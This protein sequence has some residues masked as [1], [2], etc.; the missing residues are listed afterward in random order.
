MAVLYSPWGNSQFF[1]ANG[2]PAN[3][4]KIYTYVAGSSTP[5][6]TY[7]DSTGTVAQSNPIVI[8]SLGFPTTGQIWLTS[9]LSY[10]LVLT[11]ASDVVK[12]TQDNL[13]G[14]LS[15]SSSTLSQWV[16]SGLTPTYVSAT[17]FTLAGDQTSAFHVGRRLQT[18]NTSGMIYSR[19]V[20]SAYGA[21]TTITVVNDS[22][23][24]DSGLS[25][26]NYALLTATGTS[27]PGAASPVL[28]RIDVASVAGTV[29]LTGNAVTDDIR[30]TGTNAIT[31]FTVSTG[32][33]LRVTAGGAFTLTNNASIVTQTGA[34]I[35]C[36]AG[37][38]FMLRATA[39]NVVEV[40]SYSF[41]T[42][43]SAQIQTISGSVAANDLTVGAG[44][45]TLG[46]RST[47]L[48][49]GTITTVT[50]TPSSLVVPS[51]ATLGTTNA[52]ASSIAVIALNNAGTIELAVINTA[53]G[54]SLD[55]TGLISTTAI[56]TGA[57]LANVIYSTTARSNV[58][59]RVIGFVNSTQATA[60]TWATTPSLIQGAGGQALLR[61][62][63]LQSMVRLN[64]A[65]GYGSTNTRIRRFTNVVVNQGSDITYAD[66]ATLGGSFTINTSGVY[67]L[68]YNDQFTGNTEVGWSLNSTQLST[69]ILSI[70]QADILCIDDSQNANNMGCASITVYLAA[71][72]VVRCHTS[73]SAS[74]VNTTGCQVTVTRV[75]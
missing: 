31:A 4:W 61:T 62:T 66:S 24:L 64:T 35:I 53:G 36:A 8:N 34:N 41:A 29:D 57:D 48:T 68:H 49:S 75:A 25:S 22:G 58:A 11:D 45:L 47:T 43:S 5:L 28:P 20:S 60:G 30:I 67:A 73:G 18:T 6:A 74:G 1:D 26:V 21:L 40:L 13:S 27:T 7:T 59:Y 10:K 44:A 16:A 42:P 33:V 50:G 23:V 2:D 17:S 70:T 19:I 15:S 71:G 69:S 63:P 51:G 3:G 56:S 65:N 39:A 54:V 12:K 14:V 38:T 9:G 55:E 46:F 72:S 52:V 37:D 32:R